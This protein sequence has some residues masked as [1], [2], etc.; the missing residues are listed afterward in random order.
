MKLSE[1]LL[2]KASHLRGVSPTLSA[3]DHLKQAGMS[4][5][6]ARMELAQ[7]EMEKSAATHMAGHG[8]DYDA[9]LELVKVAGVK[10]K[11]LTGFQVEK[12]VD[13]IA[14]ET[15]VK[16]ASQVQSLEDR[17]AQ[18]EA[19]KDAL[20]EK[21]AELELVLNEIPE[22]IP[23]TPDALTKLAKTTNLTHEDVEA[24]M[25]VPTETLT[26]IAASREAPMSMGRAVGISTSELDPLA[27]FLMS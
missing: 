20:I 2:K 22:E 17:L 25:R 6:E 18:V 8:I 7:G 27:Q 11:D 26:K 1:K 4:E 21:V 16:S 14:F 19:E 13:E 23:E 3:I 12:S 15:L 9:A 10:V 5:D 24:L